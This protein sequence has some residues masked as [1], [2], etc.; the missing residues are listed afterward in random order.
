[1]NTAD[2]PAAAP[3]GRLAELAIEVG[4]DLGRQ[5][6]AADREMADLDAE[7]AAEATA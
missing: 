4:I 7:I 6:A 1:M 2:T 3:L 5:Q